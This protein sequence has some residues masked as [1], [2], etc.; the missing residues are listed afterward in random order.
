MVTVR[1]AEPAD[2]PALDGIEDAAD[3]LFVQRAVERTLV[4]PHGYAVLDPPP[5][6][7]LPLRATEERFGMA[8]HGRRVA[9][10]RLLDT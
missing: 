6:H 1:P 7:L 3:A 2:L 8:R 10:V 9:M 5:D 4:R